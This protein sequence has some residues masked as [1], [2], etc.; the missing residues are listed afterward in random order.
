M[1]KVLLTILAVSV[2]LISVAFTVASSK[3]GYCDVT[4]IIQIMPEYEKAKA[5]LESEITKYQNQAEQMQV[6]FNNKYKEYTDN[7]A[8]AKTDPNKWSPAIQTVKEQEL[9]QLQQ[10]IQDFQQTAQEDIQNKQ[11][12]LFNGV[13][14]KVDSVIDV[15][16]SENNYLFIIE[17]LQDIRVNKTLLDDISPNVKQKLGLQ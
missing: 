3:I 11:V 17:N 15:V 4:T 16:I 12:E 13:Q 1:K 7:A 2:I 9:Q 14:A 8:L 10:R 5:T 6:E